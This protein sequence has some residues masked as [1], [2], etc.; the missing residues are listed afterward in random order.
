MLV[1]V[2]LMLRFIAVFV[3]IVCLT[4][5]RSAPVQEMSDA[6]QAIAAARAAGATENTS[7]DFYAAQAAITR[8]EKHLEAQEYTRARFA[9]RDAKRHAGAALAGAQHADGT[10]AVAPPGASAAGTP[11]H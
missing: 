8:A 11:P 7:P 9:A 1:S 4:G 3:G 6:R 2:T 5:C 10:G